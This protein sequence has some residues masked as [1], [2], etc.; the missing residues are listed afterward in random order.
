MRDPHIYTD[1]QKHRAATET[2]T[3]GESD[4]NR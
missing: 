2:K 4:R 1:C 3:E